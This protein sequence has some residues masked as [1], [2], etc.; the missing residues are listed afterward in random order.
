MPPDK[1]PI[2]SES[3]KPTLQETPAIPEIDTGLDVT[4][5]LDDIGQWLK[6]IL[7]ELKSHDDEGEYFFQHG[8]ATTDLSLNIIDLLAQLEHPVKGY[9]VKND[10]KN[11]IEAGHNMTPSVIDSNLQTATARFY[12]IFAGETHKEMFNRQVIRNIYIRTVTGT[13]DY[14][15]WLLW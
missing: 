15:L 11:T 1:E 8:T 9:I 7:E 5:A 6:A 12:P 2:K 14:R 10:G 3:S 13:S 4:V